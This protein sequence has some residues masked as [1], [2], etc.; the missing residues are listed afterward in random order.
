MARLVPLRDERAIGSKPH[1]RM[2]DPRAVEWHFFELRY[3]LAS[4]LNKTT[5]RQQ[6]IQVPDRRGFLGLYFVPVSASSRNAREFPYTEP[7]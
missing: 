6:N 3:S 2:F 4:E 7:N 1:R 5:G